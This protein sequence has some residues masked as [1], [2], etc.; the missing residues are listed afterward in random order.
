MDVGGLVDLVDVAHS[1]KSWKTPTAEQVDKA[2]AR[3]AH[4]EHHRHFFDRFENPE[5]LIPL[6]KKGYFRLP[7]RRSRMK[8][9]DSLHW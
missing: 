8:P 9:A 3:L 4:G 1:M 5:W 7:H 2:I 6:K